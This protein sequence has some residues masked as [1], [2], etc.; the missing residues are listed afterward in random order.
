MAK[1]R[2]QDPEPFRE[3][4]FWWILYRDDVFVDGK[5]DRK[6]KRYKLGPSEMLEAEAKRL[7]ADFFAVTER[8]G[9][10]GE[11]SNHTGGVHRDDLHTKRETAHSA[12]N[13]RS[14]EGCSG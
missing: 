3:G 6:R 12:V 4:K 1:R 2:F 7:A 5:P 13:V 9:E 10:S 11:F 14:D 8:S